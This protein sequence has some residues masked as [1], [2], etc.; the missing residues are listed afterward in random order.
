MTS[1]ASFIGTSTVR[2]SRCGGTSAHVVRSSTFLRHSS[3][4]LHWNAVR[5]TAFLNYH[6]CNSD[7]KHTSISTK[8]NTS[9]ITNTRSNRSFSVFVKYSSGSNYSMSMTKHH[10]PLT[11][12]LLLPSQ[13]PQIRYFAS[14]SKKD[15]YE[16]LGVSKTAD[17]STIKKAYFKLA[18]KYHPDTN[19]VRCESDDCTCTLFFMALMTEEF[20]LLCSGSRLFLP[21][22]VGR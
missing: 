11:Q 17:K 19:K 8:P 13:S 12:S 14:D 16:L 22:S 2:I 15:F 18:K 1:T 10:Q 7:S 20:I 6:E 5:P 21:F 3:T 4:M 9:T